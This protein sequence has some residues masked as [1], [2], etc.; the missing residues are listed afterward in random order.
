MRGR[1]IRRVLLVSLA[2][3]AISISGA[4]AAAVA[5]ATGTTVTF[6]EVGLAPGT[7]WSVTFNG[8]TVSGNG[9][10][11]N[12]SGVAGPANYS[13]STASTVAGRGTG[14]EFVT[15]FTAGTMDVPDQRAQVVPYVEEFRENLSA[16]PSGGG[17]TSP[18]GTQWYPSGAEVALVA[19][20]DP[21][22]AFQDWKSSAAKNT[23][24][25]ARAISTVV[26]VA[27]P[28]S[29]TARFTLRSAPVTFTETGL[30][31]GTSWTVDFN[32]TGHASGFANLSVGRQS[33]GTYAF[34]I[35]PVPGAGGVEYAADPST[36]SIAPPDRTLE[37][38]TF[39][40]LV[41]VT[42]AT[43]PV[44]TGGL[45]EPSIA[46]YYAN[47]SPVVVDAFNAS[48]AVFSSWSASGSTTLLNHSSASTVATVDGA[49]TITATFK[50][51]TACGS[52]CAVTFE[53]EGLPSGTSW[54]IDV[55]GVRY[56]STGPTLRV[57][58][59][60]A[61]FSWS[62]IGPIGTPSG[63]VE[64]QPSPD[65]G[66]FGVG[67]LAVQV[68]DFEQYD[69]LTILATPVCCQASTTLSGGWF[70][71]DTTYSVAASAGSELSFGE[72]TATHHG[73]R[74]A[75]PKLESTTFTV[76]GPSTLTA[77][78]HARVVTGT[79]E[80]FGLPKGTVWGVDVN[81]VS[82]TTSARELNLTGLASDV[83][84]PWTALGDLAGT[85][86]GVEYNPVVSAGSFVLP[87]QRLA[88]V[89]Y[90]T[91]YK[92]TVSAT[93][94]RGGSV[95]PSGS[96]W[97]PN[98]TL[99]G[100]SAINGSSATFA[101]WSASATSGSLPIGSSSAASTWVAL[102]G[103]GTISAKFV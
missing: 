43:A 100:L 50:S 84:H 57:L 87:A 99:W 67:G 53:E 23:F 83:S 24:D 71:N 1:S 75:S 25:D 11:L 54:G 88:A 9:T 73:I 93:G 8:A 37:A 10:E 6:S 55:G 89:V 76:V 38:V 52:A 2:L 51:G 30:P 12:I 81:G 16:L 91:V 20:P 56:Y 3:A 7:V 95:S 40:E 32:G 14:T 46:G 86:P 15:T 70:E 58:N 72:W 26:T 4:A 13:W 98:G 64:Y 78:F 90:E 22:Y 28:G 19:L 36:G 34:S 27:K 69:D 63:T 18:S 79:I 29:L 60:S 66:A 42:F 35:A 44:G 80:E 48:G 41:P 74:I 17:S 62:A 59:L 5:P 31:A 85:A 103:P 49:T 33:A 97:E 61:G 68:L 96:F 65:S 102:D 94:T 45:V 39:T 92:V 21:G 82:V 101:S 47:D 77:V